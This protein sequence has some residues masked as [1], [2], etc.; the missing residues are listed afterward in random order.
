MS[1]S[2]FAVIGFGH[3]GKKHAIMVSGNDDSDLVAIIDTDE[4]KQKKARDT[5]SGVQVFG[6]LEDFLTSDVE[7]DVVNICTPN[8]YHASQAIKAL[9]NRSHV[10]LEKP[11]GLTRQECEEVIFKSLQVSKH[12]FCVKQNRYSPSSKWMKSLME[13]NKLGRINM[14]QLSCY[15]NR[16]S[17]YY[18]AG[19]WKGT[20]NLDGG[21]LFTQFS[22]FIDIM[23][24]LF[25]DIQNIVAMSTNFNHKGS[26]EFDD[27][28]LVQ[29]EFVNGGFGS[30]N[31]STAI[32]GQNFESSIV[33][34]GEKG[35]LKVSGQYMDKV[36]YCHIED[37]EM[38]QL[39]PPNPPNDYGDYKGSAANHHYVIQNVIDVLTG[40]SQI[41]TNALEGMKVVEMIER[42]HN[43]Q[44][45]MLH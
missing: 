32:Y 34:V 44:R 42:I 24:W 4:A 40:K 43:K 14:V 28:G 30:V 26:T 16:D 9:D 17:R 35:T 39:P 5:Y 22:H 25:G 11:M 31:Y 29:F 33:V 1:K 6:S 10:V 23:Y 8:G 3:I 36:E 7:A 27:S 2:T 13:E 41:S 45:Q 12:V 21:I 15:W 20:R 38:P 19:G 37:Y 18:K